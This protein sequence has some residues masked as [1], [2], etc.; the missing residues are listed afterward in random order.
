MY[1]YVYCAIVND[2]ISL[3]CHGSH[4]IPM[5][6]GS[7]VAMDHHRGLRW[8][9]RLVLWSCQ[10][11]A[12]W[13][14]TGRGQQDHGGSP[15]ISSK[16][17]MTQDPGWYNQYVVFCMCID[18]YIY[19]HTTSLIEHEVL[20][21]IQSCPSFKETSTYAILVGALEPRNFYD[22]PYIGKN[23]PNWCSYFSE[24]LKPPTRICV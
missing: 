14:T 6:N 7:Q 1:V 5:I 3:F 16:P 24:G 8:C 2:D 11:L 13:K 10:P 17:W 21:K 19:I 9:H 12:L 4:D 15:E 18:I 20:M 22:F 23:N